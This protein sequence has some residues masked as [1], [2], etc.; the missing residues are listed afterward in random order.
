MKLNKN[1]TKIK[2]QIV[3]YLKSIENYK[4]EENFILIESIAIQYQMYLQHLEKAEEVGYEDPDYFRIHSLSSKAFSA[5]MNGLKEVGIGAMARKKL[6]VQEEEEDNG[7]LD[8]IAYDS[9]KLLQ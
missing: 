5:Y 8:V 2:T 4:V 1:G 3:K 6:L 9:T 7:I